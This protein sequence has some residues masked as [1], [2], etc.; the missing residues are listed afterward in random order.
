MY[1][2]RSLN[3]WISRLKFLLCAQNE[4]YFILFTII[5]DFK[6]ARLQRNAILG[7]LSPGRSLGIKERISLSCSKIF[8]SV[9]KK[10]TMFHRFFLVKVTFQCFKMQII[11]R[12][13][14]ENTCRFPKNFK[15]TVN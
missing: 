6:T 3:T 1:I 14:I 10:L 8:W 12:Y 9:S 15:A 7:H 2:I 13:T 5:F 4:S 11:Q